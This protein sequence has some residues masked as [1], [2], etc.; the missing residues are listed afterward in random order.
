MMLLAT[1]S[2][3]VAALCQ[4]SSTTPII[5]S[6]ERD[7]GIISSK[8]SVMPTA[9]GAEV[10]PL[11]ERVQRIK[12]GR[13]MKASAQLPHTTTEAISIFVSMLNS[14]MGLAF[15]SSGILDI[16]LGDGI[17]GL[18]FSTRARNPTAASVNLT[19]GQADVPKQQGTA[20]NARVR[21]PED[22]AKDRGLK[23]PCTSPQVI[24]FHPTIPTE[25][26]R[27]LKAKADA[28]NGGS[29]TGGSSR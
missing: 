3:L 17:F 6:A 13:E 7:G 19:I 22:M 15:D 20:S 10:D 5:Q 1:T 4:I 28:R 16:N 11:S 8:A 2:L 27:K 18:P 9:V 14:Q 23:P 29:R 26:Y 24:P 25:E 21:T 12:R